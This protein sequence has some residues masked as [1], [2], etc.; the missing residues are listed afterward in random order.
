MI[1][2]KQVTIINNRK[3][4]RSCFEQHYCKCIGQWDASKT[5]VITVKGF[6]YYTRSASECIHHYTDLN[7]DQCLVILNIQNVW[8]NI[9]IRQYQVVVLKIHSN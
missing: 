3:K 1:V 9:H 5:I 4:V 6:M 8:C 7:F 2:R